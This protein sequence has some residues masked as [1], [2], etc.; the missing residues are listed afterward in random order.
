MVHRA[1]TGSRGCEERGGHGNVLGLCALKSCNV[2]LCVYMYVHSRVLH[3]CHV[4]QRDTWQ[5]DVDGCPMCSG[6]HGGGRPWC[7]QHVPCAHTGTHRGTCEAQV[8]V[9]K[10]MAHRRGHAWWCD[11]WGCRRGCMSLHARVGSSSGLWEKSWG[12]IEGLWRC[13]CVL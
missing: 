9:H 7:M 12:G 13:V 1:S 8:G 3:V 10:D 5:G 11:R 4:G 6:T 2:P